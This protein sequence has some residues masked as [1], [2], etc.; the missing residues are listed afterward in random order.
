LAAI[1]REYIAFLDVL[2]AL[3]PSQRLF[4]EGYVTDKVKGVEVLTYLLGDRIEQQTL[5]C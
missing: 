4:V 1:F 3:A 5:S 2:G